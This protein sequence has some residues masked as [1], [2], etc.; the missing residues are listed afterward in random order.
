VVRQAFEYERV[1]REG[2]DLRTTRLA[3]S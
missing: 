3:S 1:V 2:R